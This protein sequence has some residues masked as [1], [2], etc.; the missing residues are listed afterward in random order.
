MKKSKST[1]H[2]KEALVPIGLLVWIAR[3]APNGFAL[4]MVSI[5][6]WLFL[7]NR[8]LVYGVYLVLGLTIFG[9]QPRV[10]TTVNSLEGQVIALKENGAIVAFG[11]AL[12][13]VQSEE[14]FAYKERI[15]VD[16]T[17]EPIYSKRNFYAF[18]Y[19]GWMRRQGIGWQV[20]NP[21]IERVAQPF[22]FRNVALNRIQAIPHADLKQLLEQLFIYQSGTSGRFDTLVVSTTMGISALKTMG[23]SILTSFVAPSIA[24]GLLLGFFLLY[25]LVFAFPYVIFR[26]VFSLSC[27]VLGCFTKVQELGL[28]L[29][30]SLVLFPGIQ[31]SATF[32]FP[33]LLSMLYRFDVKKV[34]GWTRFLLLT[35]LQATLFQQVNLVSTLS[36]PFVVKCSGILYLVGLIALV[37]PCGATYAMLECLLAVLSLVD[38]VQYPVVF[39][40][41]LPLALV[42]IGAIFAYG[43]FKTRKA[44][45]W[46]LASIA[47]AYVGPKISWV[48][49]VVFFDVGQGDA[50]FID[51]GF[52]L[53]KVMI[54]VAE[55]A[56]SKNVESI[57]APY[58]TQHGV[59]KLDALIVSHDDLD[60]SG[61]VASLQALLP[62]DHTITTKNRLP[63][64]LAPFASELLETHFFDNENDNS[65]VIYTK[66]G[67]LHYLFT[68]DI[69]QQV[70]GKLIQSYPSLQADV[71]KVAHHG[72]KTS[73]SASFVHQLKPQIALIGAKQNNRYQH[74]HPDVM[75]LLERE[76]I[77]AFVSAKSGAVKLYHFPFFNLIRTASGEFVIM[78]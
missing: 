36:F 66:V 41:A 33:V 5:L 63:K 74:P 28:L 44:L 4:L 54:D 15:R 60:H 55:S 70:E 24:Y 19:A 77:A 34:F 50:T 75:A 45:L 46:C 14:R 49:T 6:A 7:K 43:E 18:D 1:S 56:N 27:R 53:P 72:S 71:L 8:P 52:G 10:A 9:V 12:V 29:I 38:H 48:P 20:I 30:F 39:A 73:S 76:R 58:F 64:E 78:K 26:T 51:Y 37:V 16:A 65:I 47:I 68:G 11:D 23:Y 22:A 67:T 2:C 35:V 40:M 17:F 25:G 42:S 21:Q 31:Y 61:G 62:I 59:S 32:L 69:S 57:L 3:Y 13:L